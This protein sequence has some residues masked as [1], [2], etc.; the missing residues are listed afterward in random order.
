[1]K[2]EEAKSP[3]WGSLE[4][5]RRCPGWRDPSEARPWQTWLPRPV[6]WWVL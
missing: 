6:G 4:L 5:G 3:A 2:V 1:M